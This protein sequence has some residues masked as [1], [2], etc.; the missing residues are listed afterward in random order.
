MTGHSSLA[1]QARLATE[2][3]RFALRAEAFRLFGRVI[4]EI[5]LVALKGENTA[6]VNVA[7]TYESASNPQ[8]ARLRAD[9]TT[10]LLKEEGFE[11]KIVYSTFG[12]NL[13][14]TW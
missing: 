1:E 5:A 12:I 2:Q 4:G 10:E 13:K 6:T 3:A 9:Y 7:D 11:T 8:G 14:I